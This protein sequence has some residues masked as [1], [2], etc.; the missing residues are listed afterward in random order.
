[1]EFP[2][3]AGLGWAIGSEERVN[4]MIAASPANSKCSPSEGTS[5]GQRRSDRIGAWRRVVKASASGW[6]G[7]GFFCFLLCLSDCLFVSF[8]R[9]YFG[10]FSILDLG[11]C[12][13]VFMSY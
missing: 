12:L 7:T 5:G 6:R 10:T 13:I 3:L 1:M 4:L 8:V 2:S 11:T 9:L